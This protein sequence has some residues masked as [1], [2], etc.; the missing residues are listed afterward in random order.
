MEDHTES[1]H[2]SGEHKPEMT[3]HEQN[4][5]DKVTFTQTLLAASYMIWKL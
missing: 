2:I 3:N 4:A 5:T 1:V